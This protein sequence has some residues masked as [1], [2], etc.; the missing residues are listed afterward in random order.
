MKFDQDRWQRVLE[1]ERPDPNFTKEILG[2][3]TVSGYLCEKVRYT[4]KK[5]A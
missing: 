4:P 1:D 2:A 5:R 3:E